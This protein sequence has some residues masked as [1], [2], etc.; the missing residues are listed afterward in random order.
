MATECECG[1]RGVTVMMMTINS[2]ESAQMRV[3][4]TFE[5]ILNVDVGHLYIE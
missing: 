2:N 5:Y 3:C 1:M 4:Y